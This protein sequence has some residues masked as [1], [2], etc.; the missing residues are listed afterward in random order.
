MR[1]G[2]GFF[3][4]HVF[5]MTDKKPRITPVPTEDLAPRDEELLLRYDVAQ[6]WRC[7]EKSVERAETRLGLQPVRV[8]R[9][10]RYRLSDVLRVERE[11]FTRPRRKFTGLRPHERAELLRREQEE[12]NR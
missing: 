11:G 8:L 9:A 7:S 2:I 12:A 3:P 4:C 5:L 10:V 6:R 1:Q